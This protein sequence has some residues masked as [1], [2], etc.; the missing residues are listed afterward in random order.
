MMIMEIEITQPLMLLIAEASTFT[1]EFL[2]SSS[3]ISFDLASSFDFAN[4]YYSSQV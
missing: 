4:R 3:L 1:F 2:L